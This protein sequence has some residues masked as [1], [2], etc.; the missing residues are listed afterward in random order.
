MM[1]PF[2]TQASEIIIYSTH[3]LS[4]KSHETKNNQATRKMNFAMA[5]KQI[6]LNFL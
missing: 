6:G 5:M 4:A 2:W 3:H 1:R